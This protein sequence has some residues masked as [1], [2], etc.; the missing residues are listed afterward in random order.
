M[1]IIWQDYC[2]LTL[3]IITIIIGILVRY[4]KIRAHYWLIPF[5]YYRNTLY[6]AIPFGIAMIVLAIIPLFYSG[7]WVVVLRILVGIFFLLYLFMWLLEPR[8]ARPDWINWL[9]DKHADILP[10]LRREICRMEGKERKKIIND[11]AALEAW[12]KAFRRRRGM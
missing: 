4:G 9:E 12:I 11:Q 7:W 5:S 6:G 3:G 2:F 1:H 8:F 10:E